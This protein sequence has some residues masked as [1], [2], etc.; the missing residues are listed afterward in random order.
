MHRSIGGDPELRRLGRRTPLDH[1]ADREGWI[2]EKLD[3]DD[4]GR[5]LEHDWLTNRASDSGTLII[6]DDLDRLRLG[7]TGVDA[8]LQTSMRRLPVGLGIVFHRFLGDDRL[9]ISLDAENVATGA[10]SAA[11]MVE[12]LDPFA[13]RHSGRAGYPVTFEIGPGTGHPISLGRTSG[14]PTPR[15]RHTGSVVDA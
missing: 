6:W 8:A 5:L 2:C 13:H 3:P 7:R 10:R 4:C 11:R 9:T 15:T 12:A 1:A 14:L